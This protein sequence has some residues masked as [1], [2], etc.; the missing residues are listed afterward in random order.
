MPRQC[1]ILKATK[2]KGRPRR[3]PVV[4]SWVPEVFMFSKPMWL[5]IQKAGP[6]VPMYIYLDFWKR[7]NWSRASLSVQWEWLPRKTRQVGYSF[8]SLLSLLLVSSL[9]GIILTF[10]G[11]IRPVIWCRS[12]KALILSNFQCQH[13]VNP[14]LELSRRDLASKHTE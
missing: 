3:L 7:A 11:A 6:W 9:F 13:S 5:R 14:Y 1:L 12:R 2:D 8:F 4:L 10:L